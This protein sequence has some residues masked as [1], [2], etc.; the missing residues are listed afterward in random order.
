M[1]RLYADE[2][3]DYPIVVELRRLGHD[4]LTVQEAG[5][6]N[7]AS[8]DH[9]VL[10]S[11]CAQGR[12]VLTFNRRDFIHLHRATPAHAGIVVC[13]WDPDPV[14]LAARI[15]A[16]LVACPVLDNQLLRVYRRHR[17]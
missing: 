6:A 8:P 2:D 17:S 3:F 12:A 11:A 16:A 1:A 7:Q 15:H 10:A 4:V 9:A 5:Q 13:T 14:G